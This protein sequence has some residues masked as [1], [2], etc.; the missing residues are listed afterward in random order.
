MRKTALH[1]RKDPGE[2]CLFL[3]SRHEVDFRANDGSTPLHEAVRGLW[4]A[5]VRQLLEKSADVNA[6]KHDAVTALYK[7]VSF[8][9]STKGWLRENMVRLLL[10]RGLDPFQVIGERESA[11]SVAKARKYQKL[12]TLLADRVS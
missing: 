4:E 5:E 7:A 9:P 3:E 1:I 6:K 10:D 2:I 8:H 11:L 12:V